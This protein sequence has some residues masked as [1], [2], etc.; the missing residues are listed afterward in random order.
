MDVYEAVTSRRAVRA[1]SD[2]TIPRETLER[3]LT[4][5][6]RTPSSGNMQPW[7]CYVLTGAALAEVKKRIAERLAV[8][9]AGDER[10]YDMYPREPRSPYQERQF[11]AGAQRWGA[12]GIRRE[13]SAKRAAMVAKNWDCFGATTALMC[14]I[15]RGMGLPQWSD[16]GMFLQ[17]VMLLLRAEGLH[18]CPQMAWSEYRESVAA[19]VAP[20]P[21]LMLFCG[22]SI[23]YA[24]PSEAYARINRAPLSETVTFVD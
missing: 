20:P 4:A 19:V 21:N 22:M 12:L 5:A 2:R 8:G 17:T 13:D 15:D 1:F 24:D 14:Y 11:N 6:R 18:S 10:E 9:D 7:N 16:V 3:V 23:G